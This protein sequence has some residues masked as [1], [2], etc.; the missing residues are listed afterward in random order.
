MGGFDLREE[1]SRE[2]MFVE[3][4]RGSEYMAR[5][6]THKLLLC[7]ESAFDRLY[8]LENDPLEMTNV[9]RRSEHAEARDGCVMS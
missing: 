7:E 4:G 8:D 3:S 9:L 1:T 6:R 5:S 2:T